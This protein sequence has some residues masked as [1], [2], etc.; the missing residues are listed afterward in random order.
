VA[1][2]ILFILA[3]ITL[4]IVF[5]AQARRRAAK[6]DNKEAIASLFRLGNNVPAVALATIGRP[7]TTIK[8]MLSLF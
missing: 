1:S 4:A 3:C 7:V 5:L 8:M 2:F 6:H